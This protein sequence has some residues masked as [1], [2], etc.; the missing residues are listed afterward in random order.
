MPNFADH[1]RE[2]FR[3]NFREI[4]DVAIT[5]NATA[6]PDPEPDLVRELKNRRTELDIDERLT[7]P[8]GIVGLAKQFGAKLDITTLETS[9]LG[10]FMTAVKE[11]KNPLIG[12]ALITVATGQLLIDIDVM[13]RYTQNEFEDAASAY[14]EALKFLNHFIDQP[15]PDEATLAERGRLFVEGKKTIEWLAATAALEQVN[16]DFERRAR[17]DPKAAPFVDRAD[18]SLGV[19]DANNRFA[20]LFRGYTVSVSTLAECPTVGARPAPGKN[21]YE[22]RYLGAAPQTSERK[23]VADFFPESHYPD[24][25]VIDR[26]SVTHV[27][28]ALPVL[29]ARPETLF[30]ID[31]YMKGG[32]R[33]FG[34]ILIGGK[35]ETDGNRFQFDGQG[36]AFSPDYEFFGLLS[37]VEHGQERYFSVR[38]VEQLGRQR[39]EEAAAWGEDVSTSITVVLREVIDPDKARIRREAIELKQGKLDIARFAKSWLDATNKDPLNELER[40]GVLSEE[41]C[42][43]VLAKVA[44]IDD[45]RAR[46]TATRVSSFSSISFGS[47]FDFGGG[48]SG[49]LTRGGP[50]LHASASTIQTGTRIGYTTRDYAPDPLASP[51][52][53]I[54]HTV[55]VTRG[56]EAEALAYMVKRA[57]GEK[58]AA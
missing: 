18:L 27:I 54:L 34:D 58:A 52:I 30:K 45:A 3:S 16:S 29:P 42:T 41:T 46:E 37:N 23:V 6:K 8:N 26:T 20:G 10:A 33:R 13:P 19:F 11:L 48:G 47:S 49:F 12:T 53:M 39:A 32:P 50:A 2:V 43:A 38:P 55:G 57:F 17:E 15:T 44:E 7:T 25:A 31:Q 24:R 1:S 4:F 21:V 5:G 56:Q 35:C 40:L 9:N 36:Q 14:L 22:S 28:A 51:S